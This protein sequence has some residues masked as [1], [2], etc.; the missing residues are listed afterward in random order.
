MLFFEVFDQLNVDNSL[1]ELFADV[2]VVKVVASRQNNKVLT[3]I[4]STRLIARKII[5]KMEYQLQKQLFA[6]TQNEVQ[7]C[8]NYVLSA[9]YTLEN[10]W[11]LYEESFYEEL[12]D[13]SI[14][15]YNVLRNSE[16]SFTEDTMTLKMEDTF[17][18]RKK[19]ADIKQM[20]ELTFSQRFNH[21][22]K[23]V[24]EFLERE[25]EDQEKMCEYEYVK[26]ANVRFDSDDEGGSPESHGGQ[27]E[28][29]GEQVAASAG[30]AGGSESA[31]KKAETPAKTES[32]QPK[33]EE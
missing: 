28:S 1:A 31:A 13:V 4:Q 18:N 7:L 6:G 2:E 12:Q 19:G 3:Y 24:F 26:V 23:I 32:S 15:D 17:L 30:Q 33:K 10:L 11:N 21:H 8:D 16:I 14:L 29:A 20:L 25:E 22:V 5:K 27:P 9:Q